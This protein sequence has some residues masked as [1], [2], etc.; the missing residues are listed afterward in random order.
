[1]P[2]IAIDVKTPLP[3][4]VAPIAAG[5]SGPTIIVSTMPMP[6]QPISARTT[7]PAS[8]R[9]GRSSLRITAVEACGG[10]TRHDPPYAVGNE[11]A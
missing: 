9:R 10:S 7:G 5:P 1:M 3:S 4:P 11:D 6:I 2:K 8:L